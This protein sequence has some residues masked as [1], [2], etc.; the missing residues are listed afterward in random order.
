MAKRNQKSEWFQKPWAT[1]V[2]VLTSASVIASSGY[3][4]GSNFKQNECNLK[5]AEIIRDF[6]EKLT[7]EIVK[8]Q[9]EKLESNKKLTEEI[10]KVVKS[11]RKD[12]K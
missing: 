4:F 8:C 6:N 10:I 12:A 11:L 2:G 9:N 5:Q 1:L 3:W 7:R